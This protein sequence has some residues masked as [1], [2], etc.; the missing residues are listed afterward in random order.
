MIKNDKFITILILIMQ[1]C[2]EKLINKEDFL[3]LFYKINKEYQ[4]LYKK[5]LICQ[6]IEEYTEQNFN[7]FQTIIEEKLK[8]LSNE[9]ILPEL[10]KLTAKQLSFIVIECIKFN[11]KITS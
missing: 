5:P 2:I 7:Y 3:K 8:N 11:R 6:N 9:Q 1:L 4:E 10:N